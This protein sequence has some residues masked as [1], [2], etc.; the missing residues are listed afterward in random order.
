MTL[1][2]SACPAAA[3]TLALAT[4][5]AQP[6]TA[7]AMSQDDAHADAIVSVIPQRDGLPLL[8]NDGPRVSVAMQTP[9]RLRNCQTQLSLCSQAAWSFFHSCQQAVHNFRCRAMFSRRQKACKKNF[10]Q[11]NR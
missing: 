10:A 7:S 5:V 2:R 8:R 1:H 4:I 11:C 9:R 6:Q 3:L